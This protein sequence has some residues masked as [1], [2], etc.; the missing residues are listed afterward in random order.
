MQLPS[1][2]DPALQYQRQ[3]TPEQFLAAQPGVA[4][5]F[6]GWATMHRYSTPYDE[7]N[8]MAWKMGEG[9]KDFAK[10]PNWFSQ[11]L[12][13]GP[14]A[15]GMLGAASGALLGGLGGM[16]AGAA[17]QNVNS[18]KLALIMAIL[19]GGLGAY[20]G[21][22][23]TEAP[24]PFNPWDPA[25]PRMP[26]AYPNQQTMKSWVSGGTPPDRPA[27]SGSSNAAF[28]M[29]KQASF[30][31]GFFQEQQDPVIK[32]MGKLDQVPNLDFMERARLGQGI[33][34][35]SPTD[36]ETLWEILKGVTGAA[37]GA[38]IAKFI[39]GWGGAGQLG[40][41]VFGGYAA[42][43]FGGPTDALG[44]PSMGHRDYYGNPTGF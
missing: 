42:T 34:G 18:A 13:Q 8:S 12:N 3:L 7:R 40:A 26:W 31:G 27:F 23:R 5:A 44:F 24:K 33:R 21:S 22:K 41:A 4:Q 35:L 28:A 10:T 30:F 32:I 36:A 16:A 14:M 43:H 39:F 9:I 19:G 38:M 1:F 11:T 17:G 29:G 25:S 20:S 37:I 6:P 15:G 2:Y